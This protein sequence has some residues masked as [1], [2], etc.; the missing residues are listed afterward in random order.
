[1]ETALADR[2]EDF[3]IGLD[4]RASDQVTEHDWGTA[5]LNPSV[6]LL[7]DANWILIERPGI[8]FAEIEAIADEVIGGAGMDHRTVFLRDQDAARAMLPEVAATGWDVEHLLQMVLRVEPDRDAEAK[9]RE[10]GQEEIEPLR[11]ELIRSGLPGAGPLAEATV[12]QLLA[13]DQ[14][15]G[16]VAGDRWF[17]ADHDGEPASACRLLAADGIGQVEDVGTVEAAR[18]RG[19]GRSVTLR[20]ARASVEEGNAITFLGALADDWP[21]LMYAK[22]GFE[23]LRESFVFR[24]RPGR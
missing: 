13:W 7:W 10:V 16:E 6:P 18:G 9:V 23:P 20:A 21:R 14:R 22:L 4:R 17:V 8:G 3:E 5:F 12:D 2:L 15:L 19:L 11:R 24:R 1:M